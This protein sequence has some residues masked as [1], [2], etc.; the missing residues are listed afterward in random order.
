MT[1]V[2]MCIYVDHATNK[3]YTTLGTEYIYLV[4]MGLNELGCYGNVI[5]SGEK[6]SLWFPLDVSLLGLIL[7]RG[8]SNISVRENR[9]RDGSA[10]FKVYLW[11][12]FAIFSYR[13]VEWMAKI[14]TK[15]MSVESTVRLFVRTIRKVCNWN[16]SW[17]YCKGALMHTHIARLWICVLL[18][19][20]Q[21]GSESR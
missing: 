15:G 19:C 14:I 18:F 8:N 3:S 1:T 11:L 17:I 21:M 7:A 10:H 12:S 4:K 13:S 2:K 6:C 5:H 16:R 20:P 9:L